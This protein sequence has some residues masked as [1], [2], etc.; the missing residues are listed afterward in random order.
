MKINCKKPGLKISLILIGLVLFIGS[1]LYVIFSYEKVRKESR[2]QIYIACENMD[3]SLN[4]S[5]DECRGEIL[6]QILYNPYF[7]RF[8]RI[9]LCKY[10][11]FYYN[12]YK[13]YLN[14]ENK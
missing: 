5:L 8:D 10:V 2:E 14:Y 6:L 7:T 11:E 4:K 1:C 3:T 12:E 13:N 9:D